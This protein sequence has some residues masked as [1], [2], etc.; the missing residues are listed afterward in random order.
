MFSGANCWKQEPGREYVTVAFFV[1]EVKKN[2][3]II[4]IGEQVAKNDRITTGS[5]S[6]CDIKI[7]P[8]MVRIKEKSK[9]SFAELLTKNNLEKTTLEL[10]VG[11]ILCKPKKL[12]KGEKF[13]VQTP[14]AVAG[15]RGTQFTV[16]AD[17]RQTTRIKVFDGKVRVAKR[18]QALDSKVAQVLDV[19]SAI[20]ERESVIITK[21]QAVQAGENVKALM[22]SGK[23]ID[24]FQTVAGVIGKHVAVDPGQI[25]SFRIEDFVD[26]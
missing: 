11:K 13:V 24:D 18:V 8:S 1:G 14:T 9:L 23:K 4:S 17:T 20:K 5:R 19:G 15:V 7:G 2:G 26:E 10:N 22:A 3:R 6:S 21:Q 12:L 25:A 16:E